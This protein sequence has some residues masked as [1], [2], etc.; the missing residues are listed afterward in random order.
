MTYEFIKWEMPEPHIGLL[1]LNRPERMNALGLKIFEELK[2]VVDK[3]ERDEDVYVYLVTG[4]PRADGTPCFSAGA[5]MKGRLEDGPTPVWLA[6]GVMNQIDEMLKPSV[7]VADG[8]CTTGGMELFM[9]CDIRV[10][11]TEARFSALFA[12]LGLP[13]LDGVG[14]LLPRLVGS[15]KALELLYSGEMVGAEE[16]ERIGLVSYVTPA[17]GLMDRALE[18]A[19]KFTGSAPFALALSKHLVRE[20][21]NRSYD[22]YRTVQYASS[23]DNR[24]FAAHDIQEAARARR[25]KRDADFQGVEGPP[26]G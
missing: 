24:V 16:A 12:R 14:W 7:A 3:I 18:L 1:T 10:A 21:L 23:L 13:A 22:D 5:D 17:E 4:A 11:S 8:V 9:A 6:S 20:A 2:D 19:G 15:A 25:E 26:V